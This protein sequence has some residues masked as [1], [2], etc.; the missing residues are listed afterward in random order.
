MAA[1]RRST[2]AVPGALDG[3]VKYFDPLRCDYL[4]AHVGD[5][6]RWFI[7]THALECRASLSLGGPKYEEFEIEPG[8]PLVEEPRLESG[9]AQGECP[10]GQRERTVN[11]PAQPTQVR[12]LP[13]PSP[14]PSTRPARVEPLPAYERQ[15]GR[16]GRAVVWPKRRLTIPVGPFTEAELNVGDRL[17][18]AADGRGRIVLTRI[19]ERTDIRSGTIG[20]SSAD[21][22][23]Q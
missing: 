13:P 18:A 22:V 12:I 11:A 23:A 21:E 4:F 2:T 14:P 7:P 8:R 10:S 15:L 1:D 19:E 3:V 20:E 9:S 16:S 17:R 5:G 6:R